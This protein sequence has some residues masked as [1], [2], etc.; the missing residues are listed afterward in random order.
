MRET[1]SMF[2]AKGGD[3]V[4]A[5]A[6]QQA[7]LAVPTL[8]VSDSTCRTTPCMDA[9]N[10]A[11]EVPS[12]VAAISEHD[13]WARKIPSAFAAVGAEQRR[14]NEALRALLRRWKFETHTPMCD[15]EKCRLTKVAIN[16]TAP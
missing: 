4:C 14:E 3:E 8:K 5:N 13:Y 2:P 1:I 16:P 12:S 7:A 9:S 11:T 6:P 10:A 15:C